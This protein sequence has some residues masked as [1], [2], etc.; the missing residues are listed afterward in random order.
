MRCL[1]CGKRLHWEGDDDGDDR[2]GHDIVTKLSCRNK[3]CDTWVV[4]YHDTKK[5][6][7]EEE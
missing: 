2:V 1:Y 4:V 5:R 7:E 3:K 6:P